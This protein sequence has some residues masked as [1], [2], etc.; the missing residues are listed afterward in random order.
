MYYSDYVGTQLQI[1][2]AVGKQNLE[3]LLAKVGVPLAECRQQFCFMSDRMKTRLRDHL[4]K[5]ARDANLP[6]VFFETFSLQVGYGRP[7]SAADLVH[8]VAALLESQGKARGDWEKAFYMAYDALSWEAAKG[9]SSQLGSSQLGTSSLGVSG[10]SS[11]SSGGSSSSSSG[12]GGG[13]GSTS[14]LSSTGTPIS[15]LVDEGFRRAKLLQQ[16]V[17]AKATMV[18]EKDMVTFHGRFRSLVLDSMSEHDGQLFTQ[19]LALARLARFVITAHKAQ[20][21]WV[22]KRQDVPLVVSALDERTNS[23]LVVGV[24]AGGG[25]G[26][27]LL[28]VA[29]K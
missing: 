26:A 8:S 18:M 13:S 22:G 23:F 27:S 1:W 12:G 10:L 3:R 25:A 2:T 6:D 14:S 17:V 5:P 15:G 29:F 11:S 16:A 4:E 9:G 28:P 24:G 7:L 21:E 20:N 19:P